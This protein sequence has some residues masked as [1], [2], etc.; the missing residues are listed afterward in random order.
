MTITA[1]TGPIIAS[2]ENPG[3]YP[4][5]NGNPE[6]GPSLFIYGSG[7]LDPRAPFTYNNGQAFGAPMYGFITG[8]YV[9]VD[10]APSTIS[11]VNVAASQ[12]PGAGAITLVS[13]TGAGITAGVSIVRADTG[14]TVTGLLAIDG[15][16]APVTFG[17]AA[18]VHVWDPTK[19]VS[20]NVRLTSGGNDSGIT[21]TVSGYDIY[22]YPMTETITGANAGVAAGAK[23]F[24]Y[25]SGVTHTGSVATTLTIGTGD[26]YGFPLRVDR[27]AYAGVAWNSANITANTGFV[28]AV[29]T[30]PA[31]AT[32][33]D[34]RGT[35]AT[36]SASDGTKQ[37]QMFVTPSV[38]NLSGSSLTI[39][40]F[41]VT[42]A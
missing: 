42:Q 6:H 14:A 32:T 23:A 29:T 9:L 18:T 5:A 41:G 19:A 8:R 4:S 24:K 26:V 25:L 3:G 16:M 39:G 34:V 37:L 36:Q 13:A 7:M 35:Y 12:S 2:G 15:A 21:F 11:A 33:G 22:G 38:A 31:T 1:L 10:Q 27:F 30:S 17:Q 40:L 28:A 20:R